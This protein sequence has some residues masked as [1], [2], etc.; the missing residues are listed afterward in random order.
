MHLLL[1][2]AAVVIAF[3]LLKILIVAT[4]PLLA[5]G[6]MLWLAFRA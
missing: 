5:L 1:T 2:G 4:A 6:V 3:H